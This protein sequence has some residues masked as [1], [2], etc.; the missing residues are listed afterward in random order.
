ML[1]FGS[2]NKPTAFSLQNLRTGPFYDDNDDDGDD[3][4][5][6]RFDERVSLL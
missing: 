6:E 3:P 2:Q 5:Q 1:R 4:S